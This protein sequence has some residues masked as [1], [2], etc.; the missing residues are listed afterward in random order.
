LDHREDRIPRSPPASAPRRQLLESSARY[1]RAIPRAG[2]AVPTHFSPCRFEPNGTADC[3]RQT[4]RPSR[5]GSDRTEAETGR[6]RDARAARRRTWL[7]SRF[8]RIQ[9]NGKLGMVPSDRELRQVEL[10]EQHARA[11]FRRVTT[12]A[13]ESGRHSRNTLLTQE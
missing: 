8:P 12:L 5:V 9:L 2:H 6:R 11:A 7:Q 3:G 10:G 4:S 13:L 1:D